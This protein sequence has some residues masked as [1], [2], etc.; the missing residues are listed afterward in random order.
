VV[1]GKSC[2]P[3]GKGDGT[4]VAFSLPPFEKRSFPLFS[5]ISF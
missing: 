2:A 1:L 3:E 5:S 4:V